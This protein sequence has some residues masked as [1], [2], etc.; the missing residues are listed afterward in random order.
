MNNTY[1][2]CLQI[3]ITYLSNWPI[4]LSRSHFK[5]STIPSIDRKIHFTVYQYPLL[6]LYMYL[7]T[8]L[9]A[10]EMSGPRLIIAY[11]KLSNALAYGT[12]AINFIFTLIRGD[13]WELKLKWWANSVVIRLAHLKLLNSFCKYYYWD[14]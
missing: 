1:P 12:R 3:R 8:M 5:P 7:L 13:N 2:Y 6:G 4:F 14:K 11:I 10:W 9:T